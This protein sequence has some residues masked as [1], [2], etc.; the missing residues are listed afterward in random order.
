MGNYGINLFNSKVA[1]IIPTLK[2]VKTAQIDLTES[3]AIPQS[4]CPLV[5]PE[6]KVVPIP[7]KL[8]AITNWNNEFDESYCLLSNG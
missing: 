6:P 4:P 1:V 2:N 8:P 5:H 3:L 7:T